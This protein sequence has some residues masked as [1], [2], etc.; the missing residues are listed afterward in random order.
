[1][2]VDLVFPR[3]PEQIFFLISKVFPRIGDKLE[4]LKIT[5]FHDFHDDHYQNESEP[6]TICVYDLEK[7]KAHCTGL[8]RF[9]FRKCR[10]DCHPYAQDNLPDTLETLEFYNC[11]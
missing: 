3:K 6:Q 4:E 1:L 5:G 7:I 11:R 2:Q 8:K 10:F 9:V